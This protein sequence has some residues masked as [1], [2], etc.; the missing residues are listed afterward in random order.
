M[1]YVGIGPNSGQS[2]EE[3]E[4]LDYALAHCGVTIAKPD[5]PD[6]SEFLEMLVEWF[7]S[8]NWKAVS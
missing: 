3:D 8:G 5:A 7:F 4:A 6:A 2:V 1:I